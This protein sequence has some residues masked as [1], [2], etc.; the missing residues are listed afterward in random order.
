MKKTL[1]LILALTLVALILPLNLF[2]EATEIVLT[3]DPVEGLSV[4][5]TFTVTATL[6]GNPGFASLGLNLL[7]D[8][9]VVEFTGFVTEYNSFVKKDV[10]KSSIIA[11]DAVYNNDTGIIGVTRT[12]DLTEDGILFVANF[13]VIATGDCGITLDHSSPDKLEYKNLATEN[14]S[15][16]VN[17]TATRN[18]SIPKQTTTIPT[19]KAYTADLDTDYENVKVGDTITV[20]VLVGGTTKEFASSDLQLSYTGLTFISGTSKTLEGDTAATITSAD[21]SVR[22]IDYGK[23]YN[24]TEGESVTAYTLTFTVD[25]IQGTEG[26]A[27]VT[28]TGAKFST[29]AN[30]ATQDLSAATVTINEK[31][32]AVNPADLTVTLPDGF[33]SN[34]T[35]NKVEYGE[36][37]TIEATNKNYTYTLT[38]TGGTL[39]PVEGQ[40]GKWTITNV[41]ANVNVSLVGNPV[42]KTYT[43]TFNDLS[44]LE[45]VNGADPENLV[46][47]FTYDP[48]ASFS[49]IL[50]DNVAAQPGEAG[51]TYAVESITYA[52]GGT[53]TFT[54]PSTD[55]DR[56]YTI[57]GANITG[58][59]NVTTS[60]TPV[61]PNQFIVTLPAGYSNELSAN[62]TV[63][64]LNSS[65]TLTLTPEAGYKYTVSYK[66][67]NADAVEIT[68]WADAEGG[69]KTAT[70]SNITA[71]V[72]VTVVKTVDQSAVTLEVKQEY[73]A[74]EDGEIG[75]EMHMVVITGANL[76]AGKIYT[77]DGQPMYYTEKYNNSTPAYVY[78]VV[79]N[80][81]DSFTV[82][83]ARANVGIATATAKEI[84]YNG[85]VNMVG[86][87]NTVDANDAQFVWNM[88]NGMYNGFVEN[89]TMEKYLR[90][91]MDGNG[92]VETN[93]AAEIIKLIPKN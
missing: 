58:H 93:D 53:V 60:A 21:G 27:N 39:T 45:K 85:D 75:K 52:A 76:A 77:Y 84:V 2:A 3:P 34:A 47:N 12:E 50:K 69:K 90:A 9:A 32:F 30:A 49:F 51:V 83:A 67:G 8:S 20:D 57:S 40:D 66:M 38:A 71:N 22:I 16:S 62:P 82:E 35:G 26:S 29:A 7:W 80:A 88:Y 87:N 72:T 48:D 15:V 33:I 74:W 5:D 81:D 86:T 42:P 41:I 89:V 37:V 92:K 43:I 24:W 36:D 61:N 56:T 44:H 23:S 11:A 18:L 19:D 14:I 25:A 79:T 10:L 13:T 17:D 4:G 55:T 70:I 65:T 59:I 28:L 91:D 6:S 73:L 63:V 64:D 68:T 78:L 54:E 31:V 46:V 1:A